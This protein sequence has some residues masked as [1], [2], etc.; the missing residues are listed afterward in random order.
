M[1]RLDMDFI[2]F[3]LRY[4]DEGRKSGSRF[5]DDELGNLGK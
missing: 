5:D 2:V 1:E 4:D 3:A